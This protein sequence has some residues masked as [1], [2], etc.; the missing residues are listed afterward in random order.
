MKENK[1]NA[2]ARILNSDQLLNTA[3]NGARGILGLVVGTSFVR[4]VI[5]SLVAFFLCQ[6][7]VADTKTIGVG[8]SIKISVTADGAQPFTYQWHKNGV[9]ISGAT[10]ADYVTGVAAVV[11]TVPDQYYA[12]VTNTVG[13]VDSDIAFLTVLDAPAAPVISTQP[14]AKVVTAGSSVSFTVVATGVG[15][16]N[17]QWRKDGTAISGATLA[18]Y[19]LSTVAIS[20][21][22]NYTVSVTTTVGSV[23]SAATI[24]SSAALTVTP[25][26]PTI[27][28]QPLAQ[29][30]AI[31]GSVTF[32]VAATGSGV[33][34]YQWSKDSVAITGATAA[35]YTITGV[36]SGYAGN[37]SVSIIDTV[38]SLS[39]TATISNAVA[40]TVTAAPVAPAITAQPVAKNAVVGEAVSFSVTATGTSLSYQWTKGG[41]AISGATSATYSIAS[42]TTA[43]AGNYAVT[44]TNSVGSVT[45]G[46]VALTILTFAAPLPDGFASSATGGVLGTVVTPASVAEFT[47]YAQSTS[48]YVI[49]VKGT[50]NIG[51]AVKIK[52]NKTI[53]GI[54]A[55][56]LIVGCLDLSGGNVS[57]VIIRGL[58]ITNTA[59]DG[60]TIRNATNIF[61]THC[62]L[63]N[64]SDELI[65]IST[66]ADNVTI[67]W[68]DFMYTAAQTTHRTSLVTGAAGL[69]T[70]PVHVTLHHNMW[71]D[72]CDSSMPSGTYGYVHLFNNYFKSPAN[73]SGTV[74]SDNAQFF[75][76]FNSYDQIKD[77]LYKENVNTTLSAGLIRSIGNVFPGCTGKAADAGLSAIFTPTYTYDMLAAADVVTACT[78][79]AGNNAGA[80]S[81]SLTGYGAGITGPT[82][83]VATG[84]A[85]TLT[86]Q[87]NGFL[88]TSYQWRLNNFNITGATSASYT[89]S[90]TQTANAGI[91]TV[92][93]ARS[94]GDF[95]V[96]SPLTITL[97]TPGG[98]TGGSPV[99]AAASS[100][101]GGGAPSLWYL[102]LIGALAV[103]RARR[104]TV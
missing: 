55:T 23:V 102:V 59:G 64:C 31:G 8:Q 11:T 60:I 101:G 100:G 19:T 97:G 22:G 41:T 54:D 12:T 83:L 63:Y 38:G 34:T 94:S 76:E 99:A 58:N 29:S 77:P 73:T 5:V 47:T 74:A 67:S 62:T 66:G 75:A 30:A 48:A 24:S 65:E 15:S 7:A 50:L 46:T 1:Y 33:L 98:N 3:V 57:N 70:K 14:T 53:Q 28:T 6:S 86:S 37:Y 87:P 91:Y 49:N 32:V 90:S 45:S 43:H 89:V 25:A 68:S 84:S 92:V 71:S 10:S 80:A 9:V 85:F 103:A 2:L 21:A 78:G 93:I 96:S 79:L 39:S 61:I 104:K 69:E 81:S 44:V 88:G 26:A 56:S 95:V 82:D 27:T 52:S 36:T 18:T 20:D 13:S 72:L 51:N 42:V 17:Y 40:L 4:S 16:M 35:S